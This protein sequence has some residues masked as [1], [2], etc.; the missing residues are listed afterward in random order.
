ML[1]LFIATPRTISRHRDIIAPFRYEPV[2][3]A[4]RKCI[5]KRFVPQG[6][7]QYDL[8]RSFRQH[9]YL[10][11]GRCFHPVGASRQR[12]VDSTGTL[13]VDADDDLDPVAAAITQAKRQVRDVFRKHQHFVRPGRSLTGAVDPEIDRFPRPASQKRI[14]E[15]P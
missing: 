6:S 10:R 14:G 15:L 2:G 12:D 9:A 3:N 7:T 13:P 1:L 5:G 11:C 8:Y 4:G